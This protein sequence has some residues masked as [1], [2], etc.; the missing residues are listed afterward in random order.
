ML[1]H[2]KDQYLKQ[3]ISEALFQDTLFAVEARF[4]KVEHCCHWRLPLGHLTLPCAS[5]LRPAAPPVFATVWQNCHTVECSWL[6]AH[7]AARPPGH[8]LQTIA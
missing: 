7:P 2:N 5:P 1:D 6:S 3:N 8:A 4:G